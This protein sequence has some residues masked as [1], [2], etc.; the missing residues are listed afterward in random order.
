MKSNVKRSGRITHHFIASSGSSMLNSRARVSEYRRSENSEGRA[1]APM[2]TPERLRLIAQ[3]L[4]VEMIA[5][6]EQQ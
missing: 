3:A 6:Q 2:D 1:A 4:C 5:Q